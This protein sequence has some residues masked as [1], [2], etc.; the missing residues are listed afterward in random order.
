MTEIEEGVANWL[1]Q[2]KQPSKI[3]ASLGLTKDFISKYI[4]FNGSKYFNEDGSQS[5]LVF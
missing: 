1:P 2:K 3:P 4:I 5:Y